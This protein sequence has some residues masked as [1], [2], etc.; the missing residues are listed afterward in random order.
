MAA[1]RKPRDIPA[2]VFGRL[3]NLRRHDLD[4]RQAEAVEDGGRDD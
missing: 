3:K 1:D 2:S 4:F